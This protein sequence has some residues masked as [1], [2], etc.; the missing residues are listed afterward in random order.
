[1]G[2]PFAVCLT[3]FM[4]QLTRVLPKPGEPRVLP[5]RPCLRFQREFRRALLWQ[6][7]CT[8]GDET[9]RWFKYCLCNRYNT[10]DIRQN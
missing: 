10:L 3:G 8:E 9:A 7:C 1:M 6:N 4:A 5:F 2:V